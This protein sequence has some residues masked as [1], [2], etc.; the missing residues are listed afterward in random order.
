MTALIAGV[1]LALALIV[2]Y[3]HW[4][5]TKASQPKLQPIPIPVKTPAER[6]RPIDRTR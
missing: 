1:T 5:A 3:S 2:L 6:G 4:R